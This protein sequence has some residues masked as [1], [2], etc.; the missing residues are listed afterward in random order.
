MKRVAPSNNAPVEWVPSESGCHFSGLLLDLLT[1]FPR[2]M[3]LGRRLPAHEQ[4]SRAVTRRA[5]EPVVRSSDGGLPADDDERA[6]ASVAV[7]RDGFDRLPYRFDSPT[8]VGGLPLVGAAAW[9]AYPRGVD[10]RAVF[11]GASAVR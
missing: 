9:H 4:R 5:G 10:G 11:C 8:C 7:L 6:V 2:R 3:A 1:R